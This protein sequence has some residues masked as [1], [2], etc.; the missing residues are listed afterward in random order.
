MEAKGK[1]KSVDATSGS[2]IMEWRKILKNDKVGH[3]FSNN[4]N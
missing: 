2:G 1:T 3:L 4:Q